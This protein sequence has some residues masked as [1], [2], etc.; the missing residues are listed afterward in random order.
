MQNY[1]KAVEVQ[2]DMVENFFRPY[3]LATRM[4]SANTPAAVTAAPAP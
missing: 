3:T 2:S 1:C 4:M